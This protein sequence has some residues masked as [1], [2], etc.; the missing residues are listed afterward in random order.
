MIIGHSLLPSRDF[1][2]QKEVRSRV[3]MPSPYPGFALVLHDRNSQD[4]PARAYHGLCDGVNTVLTR[5]YLHIW[6]GN[7]M[8]TPGPHPL[9]KNMSVCPSVFFS[10]Q[11]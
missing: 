7:E 8:V 9:L 6:E 1:H 3:D 10:Y 2:Y 5:Q 11:K 4:R